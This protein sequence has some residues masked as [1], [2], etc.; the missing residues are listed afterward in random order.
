MTKFKHKAYVPKLDC[1]MIICIA[2]SLSHTHKRVGHDTTH[3]IAGTSYSLNCISHMIYAPQT[4]MMQ[5]FWF[6]LKILSLVLFTENAHDW[7]LH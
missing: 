2:L 7:N 5:N 6:I 4:K 1:Y 3:Y